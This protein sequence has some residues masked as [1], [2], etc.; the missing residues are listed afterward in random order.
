MGLGEDRIISDLHD[1]FVKEGVVGDDGDVINLGEVGGEGGVSNL[2]TWADV[3]VSDE[4]T[5]N[6]SVFE[7]GLLFILGPELD[8]EPP[9]VCGLFIARLIAATPAA[10]FADPWFIAC[11]SFS[12]AFG[13]LW[14]DVVP[15]LL[16]CFVGGGREMMFEEH[17]WVVGNRCSAQNCCRQV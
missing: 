11:F 13:S 6:R 9:V 3:E 2:V 16:D 5:T 4:L 1:W 15:V 17:L 12:P 7:N 10:V 8:D 14:V